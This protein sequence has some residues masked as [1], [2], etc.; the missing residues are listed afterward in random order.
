[1]FRSI[2]IV[3]VGQKG[4]PVGVVGLEGLY[5]IELVVYVQICGTRVL[6]Q[7]MERPT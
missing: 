7:P 3:P 2:S 4:V 6:I 1:M 5:P